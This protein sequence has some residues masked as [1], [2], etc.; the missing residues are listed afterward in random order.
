MVLG[1]G[2]VLKRSFWASWSS[3]SSL[4]V[5]SS[6][7]WNTS[8]SGAT[9]D[10]GTLKQALLLP[11]PQWPTLKGFGTHQLVSFPPMSP[12]P[13]MCLAVPEACQWFCESV[14]WGRWAPTAMSGGAPFKPSRDTHLQSQKLQL[15][16]QSWLPLP[17]PRAYPGSQRLAALP[18][19]PLQPALKREGRVA[20]AC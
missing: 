20:G 14:W 11:R 6:F 18:A 15:E 2:L 12:P 16:H 1:G 8:A 17:V 19:P 5:S 7:L 3:R 10:K 4:V 13:H 9:Q